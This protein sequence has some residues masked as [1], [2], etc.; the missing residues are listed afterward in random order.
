MS[1]I[2][3]VKYWSM[4]EIRGTMRAAGSHW[5]DPDTIRFFRCRISNKLYQGGGGVFFVTSEKSPFGPRAYSVRQF[6]L[7]GREGPEINTIGDFN[8]LTRS[9]A[10]TQARNLAKLGGGE[11]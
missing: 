5:F 2:V 10:H 4:D 9:V 3:A 7:D 6:V 11:L 8:S 1:A